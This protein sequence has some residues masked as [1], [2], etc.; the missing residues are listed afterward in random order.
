[1]IISIKSNRRHM[2]TTNGWRTDSLLVPEPEAIVQFL[3]DSSS[4]SH[5]RSHSSLDGIHSRHIAVE[6]H[7]LTLDHEQKAHLSLQLGFKVCPYIFSPNLTYADV[8][9]ES[10]KACRVRCNNIPCIATCLISLKVK[11]IQGKRMSVQP[12]WS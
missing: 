5:I 7:H 12:K 1:M 11:S 10:H 8:K 9:V 2:D 6:L 4:F 3:C